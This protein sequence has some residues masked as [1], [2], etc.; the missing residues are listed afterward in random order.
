MIE[1]VH[2]VK[3]F[4]HVRAIDDVSFQVPDGEIAGFLGPNGAGKTTTM[5]ILAGIFPPTT[6]HAIV[7]GHD[8]VEQ[9]LAA[10]RHVGYFPES[11][12]HYP[13][14]SVEGYLRFVA[15]LKGLAGRSAAAAA[16]KVVE[17]CGLRDVTR[18]L[19]GKL[20]KGYRQRVG[21]AQALLG[22]PKVLI[23]D[24]PTS[25]LDPEQVTEIRGLIRSLRGERTVL[26]SSHVL[27]E[28]AL[29]CERV[30]VI[31][32]GRILAVDRPEELAKRLR[33]SVRVNLRVDAP[34][35]E[36]IARLRTIPGMTSAEPSGDA[37]VRLEAASED[38]L[39]EA[40]RAI[41]ARG[42]LVLEM[43]REPLDLESIFLSLVRTRGVGE[44]RPPA[45]IA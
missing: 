33:P 23:L 30:I 15:R 25:G 35:G 4:G 42:W 43:N 28:V 40:A 34:R 31:H 21:L 44:H 1:A 10:R 3:D 19:I 20:S 18:R 14:L 27:A 45:P 13:E 7:A 37:S 41:Q 39:R 36:V 9:P 12:P 26:L 6:G 29:V 24:E 32:G 17:S 38:A 8:T 22:D 11:A 5:R 2:L 16:G